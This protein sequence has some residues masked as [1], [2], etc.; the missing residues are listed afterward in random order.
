MKI[1]YL[2][3]GIYRPA[4]MERVLANKANWFAGRGDDVLIVTTDQKG[5]APAFDLDSRIRTQDLGIGYEGNNGGPFLDK[6]VK[7]P[8]KQLCHRIRLSRLLKAEK[9]NV[10]VSM[11]CN[12][13]SFLPRIKDGSRKVL[14]VHFSRYK[15]LQ[16]GRKGLWAL[17][18]RLRSTSDV[19]AAARFDRFV[20]LTEEALTYW[21]KDYSG[22]RLRPNIV[23][24]PNA[25]TFAPSAVPARGEGMAKTVLA[26]GRYSEQ[27]AFDRLGEAWRMIPEDKREGWRLRLVGD[28]EL[29]ESLCKQIREAGLEDRVVL[30]KAEADMPGVYANA[31]IYALCSR[32]EGLPMVL[33]EAQAAGLP[34]VAMACKCGPKDVVT[35]GVDGF[36]VPE[37]DVRALADR[38]AALMEDDTLRI[39]MS[40]AAL[41]SSERFDESTIMA[42]WSQLFSELCAQ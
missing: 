25:R 26:V 39:R 40:Q 37:G 18:D 5:R 12:D 19:R 4:G 10:V 34:I 38:L 17:A 27:K 33:L 41:Q 30:G 3:A 32:Y 21:N 20:G 15:R 31:D 13:V 22:Y 8:F 14:E 2:I 36:L 9:A 29:R 16:Y 24:I 6:L 1:I 23:C 7:Y 11:F 42:G 35:D 28:G